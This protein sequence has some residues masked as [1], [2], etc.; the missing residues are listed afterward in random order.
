MSQNPH[1]FTEPVSRTRQMHTEAC[2]DKPRARQMLP[3]GQKGADVQMNTLASVISSACLKHW[4][5]RTWPQP[6]W[7][8]GKKCNNWIDDNIFSFPS[9]ILLLWVFP[10]WH[11]GLCD[12]YCPL[13]SATKAGHVLERLFPGFAKCKL[14]K[15]VSLPKRG[16]GIKG[17]VRLDGLIFAAFCTCQELLI[18][19]PGNAPGTS[20]AKRMSCHSSNKRSSL[21]FVSN[22]VMFIATITGLS[23]RGLEHS[24]TGGSHYWCVQRFCEN[25]IEWFLFQQLFFNYFHLET[26]LRKSFPFWF[27]SLALKTYKLIGLFQ[28]EFL[29]SRNPKDNVVTRVLGKRG[30]WVKVWCTTAEERAFL[31]HSGG[32]VDQESVERIAPST[33]VGKIVLSATAGQLWNCIQ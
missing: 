33:S 26:W 4:Q 18:G 13:P 14:E 12:L 16:I 27:C 2:W 7:L 19:T 1:D 31:V 29:R 21:G 24:R 9:Q 10:W 3:K 15:I 28:N 25:G 17:V 23:R 30:V 11:W 20:T 5:M 32:S 8:L 6:L 22:C